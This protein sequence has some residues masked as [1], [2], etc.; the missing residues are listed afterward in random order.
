MI[1]GSE[2]P[3]SSNG[4]YRVH[5]RFV[6]NKIAYCHQTQ[7][8]RHDGDDLREPIEKFLC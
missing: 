2:K 6:D 7:K 3:A 1:S 4:K 5:E 8:N